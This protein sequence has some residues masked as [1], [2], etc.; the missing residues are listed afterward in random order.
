MI[1]IVE[2]EGIIQTK[3]SKKRFLHSLGVRDEAKK[4]AVKYGANSEKVAIAGLIHDCCKELTPEQSLELHN[5]YGLPHD[6]ILMYNTGLLHGPLGAE[7]ARR[8]FEINDEEILSAVRCH[9]TGKT[10]MSIMDKILY[11]AD[12]IEPTRKNYVWLKAMRALAYEDIDAAVVY[13]L[14]ISIAHV[15]EKN[16]PIYQDTIDAR[17]FYCLP[18]C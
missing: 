9:T 7:Y 1:D 12:Y 13:G 17:N 11:I 6:S 10:D 2:I 3:L 18:K 16:E 8:H 4:L 14:N 15:I 5:E